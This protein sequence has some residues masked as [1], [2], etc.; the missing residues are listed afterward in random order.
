MHD[1]AAGCSIKNNDLNE[2]HRRANTDLAKYDC[3]RLIVRA[4]HLSSSNSHV[5]HIQSV[6]INYEYW[7]LVYKKGGN[8]PNSFSSTFFSF[9]FKYRMCYSCKIQLF[10][11]Q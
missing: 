9:S 8:R 7:I 2:L 6:V 10:S 5:S 1:N 4:R 11:I 3:Y